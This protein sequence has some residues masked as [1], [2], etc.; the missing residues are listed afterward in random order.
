[1]QYTLTVERA[2]DLFYTW[3]LNAQQI[4]LV[5]F[6]HEVAGSEAGRLIAIDKH[7]I[8]RAMPVLTDRPDT[9]YRLLKQLA[10]AGVLR[11]EIQ[12]KTTAVRFTKSYLRGVSA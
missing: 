11:L 2:N 7:D 8:V 1:M 9:A 4:L 6:I 10:A 12:P 3:G 5:G